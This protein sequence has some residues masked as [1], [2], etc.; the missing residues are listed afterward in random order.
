MAKR[1]EN[2][3]KNLSIEQLKEVRLLAEDLIYRYDDGFLYQCKIRSY[4]RNW[5]ET[6]TN[7]HALQDLCYRYDGDDG[8]IDVYTTNPDLSLHNYGETYYFP[9]LADAEVWRNKRYLESW[10]PRW[11]EELAAWNNRE[12]VPF[13]YRPSFAP[14]HDQE[15]I[16][17]A[18]A[19][20]AG[21]TDVVEPVR[22]GYTE[23][24]IENEEN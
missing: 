20:L 9:T 24:E 17:Q 8:I 3:L 10:I 13:Q 14:Y 22:L 18:K 6:L 15:S 12:N 2:F 7:E 19:E 23:D 21:M 5:T 1:I 11:E 16:D 4:G